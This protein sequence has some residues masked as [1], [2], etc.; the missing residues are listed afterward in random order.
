MTARAPLPETERFARLRLART[1]RVGP[2]AFKQLLDRFGTAERAVEV[3]V[4]S[5][6]LRRA[7]AVPSSPPLAPTSPK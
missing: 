7:Q 3:R 2:V 6:K 5:L 4:A 1:D